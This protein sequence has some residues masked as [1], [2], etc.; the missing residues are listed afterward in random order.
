MPRK[1]LISDRTACAGSLRDRTSSAE[2][3][4]DQNV[5]YEC[6]LEEPCSTWPRVF[7]T[8]AEYEQHYERFHA[9]RCCECAR[10]FPSARFLALHLAEQHDPL[11]EARAARGERTFACFIESC[12]KFCR[13]SA[14]RRQ[15]LIAKHAF[16]SDFRFNIVRYG[17]HPEAHSLLHRSIT[18]DKTD[19]GILRGTGGNS[20]ADTGYRKDSGNILD[21]NNS[22]EDDQNDKSE[23]SGVASS[24][25]VIASAAKPRSSTLNMKRSVEDSSSEEDDEISDGVGSDHSEGENDDKDDDKSEKDSDKD[26]ENDSITERLQLLT[27]VPRQVRHGLQHVQL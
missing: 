1:V 7:A 18:E 12:D 9:N 16:P 3:V 17:L 11:R 8:L 21:T 4:K 27:L 22:I 20:G 5:H 13:S 10:N 24:E 25:L 15:H 14:T 2:S 6:A 23:K 26:R 19:E